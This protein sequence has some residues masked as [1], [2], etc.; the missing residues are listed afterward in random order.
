LQ[1]ELLEGETAV[2][3]RKI[4]LWSNDPSFIVDYLV[5]RINTFPK[6]CSQM[7]NAG[8]ELSGGF[9]PGSRIT[10]IQPKRLGVQKISV[11]AV[12]FRAFGYRIE[13]VWCSYGTIRPSPKMSFRPGSPSELV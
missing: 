13:K 2:K 11:I 8:L 6:S 4:Y 10:L 7:A 5:R 12:R 1:L 9:L 3:D